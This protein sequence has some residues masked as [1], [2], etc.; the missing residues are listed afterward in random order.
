MAGT[1]N[2][3]SRLPEAGCLGHTTSICPRCKRLL[4]AE[5]VER[6]GRVI[7]SRACPDHGRF[8]AVVYGDA[9]RYLEISTFVTSG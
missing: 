5:L 3:A 7:L 6:E 2:G 4:D 8:E 1:A 9:E